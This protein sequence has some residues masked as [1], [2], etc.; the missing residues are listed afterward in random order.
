MA[1]WGR[2]LVC[3]IV[4][5][6]ERDRSVQGVGTYRCYLLFAFF[7]AFVLCLLFN[8]DAVA[9]SYL[10]SKVVLSVVGLV[11]SRVVTFEGSRGN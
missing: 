7:V 10:F 6:K 1:P 4:V 9:I 5:V 3:L 8:V 11:R 2:L